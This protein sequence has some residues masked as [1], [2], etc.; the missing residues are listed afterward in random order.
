MSCYLVLQGKDFDIDSFEKKCGLKFDKRT[1]KGEKMFKKRPDDKRTIQHSTLSVTAS[2]SDFDNFD[3]QVIEAVEF[4]E[5]NYEQLKH[6]KSA[7]DIGYAYLDFG[8]SSQSTK[9]CHELY[10]LPRLIEL[11]GELRLSIRVSIYGENATIG[12]E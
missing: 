4:L 7:D 9:F 5:N 10:F 12:N 1:Y 8:V 11:T 2:N 6:I 3:N